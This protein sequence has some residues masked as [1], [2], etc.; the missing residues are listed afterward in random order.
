MKSLVE[1]INEKLKISSTNKFDKKYI[2]DDISGFVNGSAAQLVEDWV[3]SNNVE[4]IEY[5]MSNEAI[6]EL[7][8]TTD[9]FEDET[10][11]KINWVDD[12]YS[13]MS[14]YLKKYKGPGFNSAQRSDDRYNYKYLYSGSD[15]SFYVLVKKLN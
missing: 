1:L 5:Y 3:N 12:L 14:N 9:E 7:G 15:T 8:F 2:I 13:L 4:N 11:F 10:I 6:E